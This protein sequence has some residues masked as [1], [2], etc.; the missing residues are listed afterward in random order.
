MIISLTLVEIGIANL[1]PLRYCYLSDTY[2]SLTIHE[3]SERL[4]KEFSIT[5]VRVVD[6]FARPTLKDQAALI[7]TAFSER[8]SSTSLASHSSEVILPALTNLE[9]SSLKEDIINGITEIWVN[10]LGTHPNVQTNFFDAGGHRYVFV[11]VK[12]SVCSSEAPVWQSLN[13]TKPFVLNGPLRMSELLTCF[14][15]LRLKIKPL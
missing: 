5:S 2:F 14:I 10:I 6:L 1:L 12:F 7:N 13:Y 3:L 8:S 11:I 9:A 15:T 4:N